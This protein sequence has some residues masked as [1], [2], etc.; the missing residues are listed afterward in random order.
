MEITFAP[1]AKHLLER[2]AKALEKNQNTTIIIQ[3]PESEQ[4]EEDPKS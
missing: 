4:S 1:D 2:I 3:A